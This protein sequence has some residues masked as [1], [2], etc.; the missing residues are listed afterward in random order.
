MTEPFPK[1]F[2]EFV[3]VCRVIFRLFSPFSPSGLFVDLPPWSAGFCL[4]YEQSNIDGEN[5]ITP[6]ARDDKAGG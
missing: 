4:L 6:L 1:Y 3:P 5:K 2:T